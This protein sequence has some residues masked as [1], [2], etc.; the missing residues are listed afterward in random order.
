MSKW[1]YFTDEETKGMVNDICFKLDR[2]REF[3]GAPIILT[4]GYRTP[5]H[6]AE[7]GGVADSAHV[8]GMAADIQAPLD[9]VTRE[10]LMWALGSAGFRRVETAPK[11]IHVDVDLSKPIPCFW[12]GEDH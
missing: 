5:E 4:C 1:E 12:V 7:V 9:S 3:F 6:N 2:A 11:H 8:K 10:K